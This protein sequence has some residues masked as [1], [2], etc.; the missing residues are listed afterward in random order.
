MTD[1]RI[2]D[3]AFIYLFIENA[4][5]ISQPIYRSMLTV[6]PSALRQKVIKHLNLGICYFKW[7]YFKSEGRGPDLRKWRGARMVALRLCA[8]DLD[9]K[10]GAAEY[11]RQ[12]LLLDKGVLSAALSLYEICRGM[13]DGC[14]GESQQYSRFWTGSSLIHCHSSRPASDYARESHFQICRR[15]VPWTGDLVMLQCRPNPIWVF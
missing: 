5:T 11:P 15:Q 9:E 12:H 2:F 14:S 4:E 6:W 8:W 3:A 13:L 10:D 1:D 7:H